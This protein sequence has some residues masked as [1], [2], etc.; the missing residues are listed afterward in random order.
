VTPEDI[1][2]AWIGEAI[3]A[4]VDAI[5]TEPIG[6]GVGLLG[7]LVRVT[8]TSSSPDAPASVIVKLPTHH[9]ANR[10]IG[11]GLM[12]Y[13]RE[14][15]FYEELAPQSPMLRVPRCWSTDHDSLVLVLEDLGASGYGLADQVAG[16]TLDQA[17]RAID[18]IAAFH[19]HW[20]ET[21]ALHALDWLPTSDHP[22]TM[23]SDQ[24]FQDGWPLFC[25]KWAHVVPPGGIELGE[26]VRRAYG[27]MLGG[28]G[29]GPHTVV[30]TDFRLDNLFFAPDGGEVAVIDWQ[31]MTRSK[32]PYDIGYLLAQSMDVDLRRQHSDALLRRWYDR[33]CSL[34]VDGYPWE[35]AQADFAAAVLVA[36]VIPVNAG[37]SIEL[38]NERGEDLLRSISARGFGAALDVDY[39]SVLRPFE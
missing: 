16:M 7:D 12:L 28:L 10:A 33:V 5:A 15:R 13:E 31:L 32:G 30:H 23:Q 39:E 2:A 8:I 22:I 37:A 36:L 25:E 14:L 24:M 38:G 18:A 21:S 6:V 3:G 1:S 27:S 26:R 17:E 4:P 11:L 20:W 19:A 35:S 34:G 9:E 29:G